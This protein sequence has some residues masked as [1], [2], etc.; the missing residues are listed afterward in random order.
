MANSGFGPRRPGLGSGAD[1][2]TRLAPSVSRG[3]R[4]P[5]S[6]SWSGADLAARHL[7]LDLALGLHVAIDLLA[8]LVR[9]R[10]VEVNLLLEDVRQAAA[11][12]ADVVEVLHEH[13]RVHRRQIGRVVHLLHA[14]ILATRRAPAARIAP[15]DVR[16]E[17]SQPARRPIPGDRGRGAGQGTA[18]TGLR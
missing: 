15:G 9:L 4:E 5:S 13:E 11:R 16:S 7:A 2:A 14:G 3:S 17:K 12:H 18:P 10:G 8:E 6:R 1:P